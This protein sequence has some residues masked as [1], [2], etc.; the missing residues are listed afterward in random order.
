M[1]HLK[2]GRALG[3]KPA[4]RRAMMRNMVTSLLEHE[5]IKTTV[6]R[7]KE[8]RKPLDRMITLGKKGDLNSRRKALTFIKSKK[9]MEK[10]FGGLAERYQD[11]QGGFSRIIRISP[12]KGD[13]AEMALI[14]LLGGPK[15]PFMDDVPVKKKGKKTKKD[16]TVLEEV[17]GKVKSKKAKTDK[18]IADKAKADKKPEAKKE[19]KAEVKAE[20]KTEEKKETE[21]VKEDPPK[22]EKTD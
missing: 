20:V 8:L 3:V 21:T 6:A 14:Q 5:Q 22:E 13:A 15:D 12:R 1:R 7:A 10:L 16:K 11:R 17:S 9:A 19:A 18:N 2:A 4:H